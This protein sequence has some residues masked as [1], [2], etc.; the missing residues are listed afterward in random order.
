M[1]AEAPDRRQV[2]QLRRGVVPAPYFH[3]GPNSDH[4]LEQPPEPV[5]AGNSTLWLIPGDGSGLERVTTKPTFDGFP[6]FSPDG[7]RL[8]FASNRGGKVAGETNLSS[9]NWW[10]SAGSRRD[11]ASLR[12]RRLR[13]FRVTPSS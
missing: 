1:N 6:M 5:V 13:R 4:L 10:S 7:K 9:R 2:T 8:V 11:L 3:A 12:S